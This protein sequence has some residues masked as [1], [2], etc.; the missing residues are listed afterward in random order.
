MRFT[1]MQALCAILLGIAGAAGSAES[2]YGQWELRVSNY[3]PNGASYTATTT[4]LLG[5]SS[6]AV[7][8]FADGMSADAGGYAYDSLFFSEAFGTVVANGIKYERWVYVGPGEGHAWLFGSTK[9]SGTA[10]LIDD[11]CSAAALGYCKLHSNILL[12]ELEAVLSTST[13][14]TVS[15]TPV[16]VTLG[17][18]GIGVPITDGGMEQKFPDE[19]FDEEEADECVNVFIWKARSRAYVCVWADGGFGSAFCTASMEG[20]VVADYVLSACPP[21]D[22]G[23][24]P[25]G[26]GE[27]DPGTPGGAGTPPEE[28]GSDGPTSPAP[29]GPGLDPPGG[30]STPGSGRG[31]TPRGTGGY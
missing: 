19:A 20:T 3:V 31:G 26:G 6:V 9:A 15:S 4:G 28:G 25:A 7:S 11:D 16:T 24:P 10:D 18:S 12:Q 14:S 1:G 22:T 23:V 29:H 13:G 8:A 2:V 17:A 27:A 30:G 21:V 5:A